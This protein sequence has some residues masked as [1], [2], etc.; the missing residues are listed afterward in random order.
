MVGKIFSGLTEGLVDVS[1][2]ENSSFEAG[3]L[4]QING[5]LNKF[6]LNVTG[7][8]DEFRSS[9]DAFKTDLLSATPEQLDLFNLR[10]ISLPRFPNILQIGSKKPAIQYSPEL[11][12]KLLNKLVEA[13]PSDMFNGVKIPNIPIG[14]TFADTFSASDFPG[15]KRNSLCFQMLSL[16]GDLCPPTKSLPD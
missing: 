10:P 9:Y 12:E 11:K 15:E 4:G 7:L 6:G 8:V 1:S 16:S 14:E 2:S 3:P 5:I 13:F